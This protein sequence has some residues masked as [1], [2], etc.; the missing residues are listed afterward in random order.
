MNFFD[1]LGK[2]KNIYI[3]G[4]GKYGDACGKYLA[5]NG[6]KV[7]G[8]VVSD[9]QSISCGMLNGVRV[10]KAADVSL[11]MGCVVV[12]AASEQY[13]KQI[14]ARLEGNNC[15]QYYMTQQDYL[16]MIRY[17]N[18]LDLMEVF[19]KSEPRN[20]NMGCD[21]G[22]SISRYY[23]NKWLSKALAGIEETKSTCEVGDERYTSKLFPDS[24]R[25]VLLLANGE[26]LTKPESLPTE[27]FDVF[28]CTQVFNFIFDVKKAITGARS[29]LKNGGY[30][31]GTVAGN[32]SQVSKPD[33]S[34]YGDYWR[35][36]WLSIKRLLEEEFGVGK[37]E[38]AAYGNAM[39]ATAY[40]QG[41]CVE[42]LPRQDLLDDNDPVYAIVIGFKARRV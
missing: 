6:Y 42:D 30:L 19:Y 26:D 29:V 7:S 14:E 40:I 41:L 36:T 9:D 22:T 1:S 34:D 21:R 17:L 16:A 13:H 37:V 27:A 31:I 39:S 11:D 33:M 38:V 4:A 24:N 2:E 3:Y 5:K 35:F 20:T 28:I 32:I 15:P 10:S 18:P 23:V 8:Y 25:H 12:I